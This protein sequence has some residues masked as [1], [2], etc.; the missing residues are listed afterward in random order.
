MDKEI[1]DISALVTAD[2]TGSLKEGEI[3]D[4]RLCLLVLN[5]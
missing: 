2:T 5:L 4:W 1:L 3:W